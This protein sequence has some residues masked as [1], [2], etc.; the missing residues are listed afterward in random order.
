MREPSIALLG[1]IERDVGGLA[2]VTCPDL[3]LRDWL[4]AE[5]ESLVPTDAHAFRT[6]S[7]REA[8]DAP[9]RLALLIPVN[10]A[11]V[12]RELDGCRD[13][14]LEPARTQPLVLFL[15]RHGDGYQTLA[16]EAPSVWSWASGSIVDPEALA[17]LDLDAERARFCDETGRARPAQCFVA[18]RPQGGTLAG[19][20]Y[21]AGR[22]AAR[23]N[24]VGDRRAPPK[25]ARNARAPAGRSRGARRLR[26]RRPA[27]SRRSRS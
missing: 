3:D 5:V 12:V 13:Q 22:R 11:E 7:V 24:R 4:V 27:L 25:R 15:L 8:L 14:A 19:A 6:R 17:E 1:A 9:D 20:E 16:A 23:R 21:H 10:E 26:P 18:L 2:I